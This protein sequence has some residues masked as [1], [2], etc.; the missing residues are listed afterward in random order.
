[1]H[2]FRNSLDE[3]FKAEIYAIS[4]I[5]YIL[6]YICKPRYD[7]TLSSKIEVLDYFLKW[8]ISFLYSRIYS[9]AKLTRP[10][11]YRN[12]GISILQCHATSILIKRRFGDVK[13]FFMRKRR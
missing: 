4:N 5:S 12:I 8:R 1:M 9:E 6:Q 10:S 11:D 13:K 2:S 3:V 7:T